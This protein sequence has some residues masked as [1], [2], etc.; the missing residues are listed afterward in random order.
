MCTARYMEKV[1]IILPIHSAPAPH[2]SA[3]SVIRGL[4]SVL[5]PLYPITAN[6][7]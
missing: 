6:T 3:S 4:D 2:L 7:N 1:K 5:D